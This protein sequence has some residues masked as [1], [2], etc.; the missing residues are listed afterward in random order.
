MA[1]I[2]GLCSI[3]ICV[4][5]INLMVFTY[6]YKATQSEP[7]GCQ[8]IND[9]LHHCY[10]LISMFNLLSNK[11][12]STDVFI[13]S[14]TYTLNMS[15][16]LKNL[17]NITIQSNISKPAIIT[18]H[19]NSN[20]DSGIEFLQVSNIT[21]NHLSIVGCGMKHISTSYHGKGNFISVRSAV[22]IQE[23]TNVV[24]VSVNISYS[25]GIGLLMYDTNGLVKITES[26]FI[27]NK[28]DSLDSNGIGGGIYV[29]FT[30]CPPGVESC[31]SHDN[32]YNNNSKYIID[33]C[34]FEGNA[35]ISNFNRS[36][37][38]QRHLFNNYFFIFSSGGGLSLWFNGQ[39]KNNYVKVLSSNFTANS[40]KDGGGLRIHNRKNTTHNHVEIS[41][42]IFIGNVGYRAGGGLIMGNV[43]Y[44]SGGH[45]KFNTYNISHCLFKRNE[46]LTGVGGGVVGYGSREPGSTEPTNRF[47]IHDS[48]FINNK[49]Q[50]GTAIQ[51]NKQYFDSTTVGVMF[52]LVIR[53]C[54]FTSN[55]L[56]NN[57]HTNFSSIGAVAISDVNVK[58]CGYTYFF[59]NTSTAL[60]VDGATVNFSNDSM[61]IFEN[62]SGLHGG[63]I[64]LI[65]G[66]NIVIFPNSTLVFLRN[67][68]VEHGGAIYVELST[69]FDF[70]LS[71]V[72]FVRYFSETILPNKWETN[73]T[74]I[75]NTARQSNSSIFASTLEP[76]TRAYFSGTDLFDKKPFY[77]YHDNSNNKISTSPVTFR[78][79]NNSNNIC[80][81]VSGKAFELTCSVVPGEIFDLPV[82][83]KD[84]LEEKVDTAMF[85]TSC[86][87]SQ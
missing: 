28:L 53:N 1:F 19:K 48:S 23:S 36:E 57:S 81:V 70:L 63:A 6:H 14:G 7:V 60:F 13:H 69:P 30:E 45:S 71:H 54:N 41:G 44:Q 11:K 76:C 15:Y 56:N 84:E 77:H 29:E 74:F 64:S 16:T 32:P 47:E 86:T 34:T 38:K 49:A 67:T 10:S 37:V 43:I 85:I 5:F 80:S 75:S 72:C 20:F 21:I 82:I 9:T 51:I 78:F 25:T 8:K 2:M 65:D 27:S 73:F 4:C 66:A 26:S 58:F 87:G 79:L 17:H 55:N 46:A 61:T 42:C 50:F 3:I 62:N 52:I 68:A 59:N 24:L 40:A 31:N 22:F 39:A 35:A 83:L 12:N 33:H 18:C